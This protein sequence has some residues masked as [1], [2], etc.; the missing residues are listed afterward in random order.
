MSEIN[1][2]DCD[3]KAIH[4]DYWKQQ[5]QYRSFQ[6]DRYLAAA[7]I[8]AEQSHSE[9]IKNLEGIITYGTNTVRLLLL[10]NGGAILSLLTFIGSL[11]SKGDERNI[12]VA[13]SF[14]HS[15]VPAFCCFVCGLILAAT[16][17]GVAYLNFLHG[18][19]LWNGPSQNFKFIHGEK[20]PENPPISQKLTF[21]TAWIAIISATCSLA[22]FGFG[23]Y[24]VAHGFFILGVR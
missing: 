18:S 6:S 8:Y 14:T 20:V 22:S 17:S 10:L 16:T 4:D 7:R 23:S 2:G 5:E 12:L 15:L 21:L 9:R 24:F 13:S 11:F 1:K 3:I 19:E